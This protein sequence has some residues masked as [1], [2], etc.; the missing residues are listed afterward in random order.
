[1][2]D[3]VKSNVLGSLI[4]LVA[5]TLIG[6]FGVFVS[7]FSDGLVYERLVTILIVL[8]IYGIVGIV[9]G[10]LKP[11]YTWAYML[12][13]SMPG[14][15]ILLIYSSREFNILYVAYMVLIIAFSFFGTKTG[16]SMKRKKK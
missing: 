8:I 3:V 6:F 2:K 12:S 14:V 10:F 16:K 1:M 7:V 13:L 11:L 9:L 4:T 5:G 15:I